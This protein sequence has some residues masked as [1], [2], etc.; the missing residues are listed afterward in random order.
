[1][2]RPSRLSRLSARTSRRRGLR[3][4]LRL[5]L[6]DLMRPLRQLDPLALQRQPAPPDQ[7]EQVH[8]VR[9]ACRRLRAVFGLCRFAPPY[10]KRAQSEVQV[11][12][13]A[14]GAVR[15]LDLLLAWLDGP[16]EA[17]LAPAGEVAPLVAT[18]RAL[19]Q[20]RCQDLQLHVTRFLGIGQEAVRACRR[21]LRAPGRLGGGAVRRRYLWRLLQVY[22]ALPAARGGEAQA[23]HAL[24]ILLKKL[25]YH[26]ELLDGVV[27]RAG[28]LPRVLAPL[29]E[30]LG[31]IH[32]LDARLEALRAHAPA[33]T[34]LRESAE[35][36]R[37]A[38]WASVA[39][40]LADLASTDPLAPFVRA[41]R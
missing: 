25:R 32:D 39:Q 23:L 15:D 40:R 36:R 27:R 28:R 7:I 4:M 18:L 35:T 6:A 2:A 8:D 37:A 24:R 19:R 16:G 3:R 10:R 1:M 13:H 31:Q 9:V 17:L 21:H 26:A 33:A 14:L 29:Q 34:T 30:G 20:G 11:L 41:A 22:E 12:S 38:C 5:R